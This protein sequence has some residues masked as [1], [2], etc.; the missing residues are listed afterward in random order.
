MSSGINDPAAA[1]R[2]QAIQSASTVAV[3]IGMPDPGSVLCVAHMMEVY[4]LQ[5]R[6]AAQAV[7]DSWGNPAEER[8]E[9]DR[10]GSELAQDMARQAQGDVQAE[11]LEKLKFEA[12]RR[13]LNEAI[14][15]VDGI[16]GPLRGYLDHRSSEILARSDSPSRLD[17][18][19]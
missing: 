2:A 13:N 5:G 14:V 17:L 8:N 3:T 4:I 19:L 18:G 6:Q 10:S 16:T 9:A 11:V 15:T 7:I 1:V 12:S